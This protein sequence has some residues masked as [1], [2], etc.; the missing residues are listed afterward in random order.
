MARLTKEFIAQITPPEKG[1]KVYWD[2]KR[3]GF[4]VRVLNCIQ[5]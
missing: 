4:G 5:I 3:T 2:D 1:Y